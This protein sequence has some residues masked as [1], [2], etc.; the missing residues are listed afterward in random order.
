[1]SPRKS[2]ERIPGGVDSQTESIEKILRYVDSES[3][4][5]KELADWIEDEFSLEGDTRA[6]RVIRFL[7]GI[8]MLAKTGERLSPGLEGG[9]WLAEGADAETHFGTFDSEI[10]GFR[11]ILEELFRH[12]ANAKEL[13]EHLSES[14]GVGWETSEQVT[15]RLNYLRSIGYVEL[16]EGTY[17]L[18]EDGRDFIEGRSERAQ[19]Q[20]PPDQTDIVD[21]F[22]QDNPPEVYLVAQDIGNF[23]ESHILIPEDNRHDISLRKLSSNALFIHLVDD[24]FRGYSRQSEAATETTQNGTRYRRVPVNVVRFDDPVGIQGVIGELL[25]SDSI[26]RP[27]SYPFSAT[28]LTEVTIGE[29]GGD[30]AQTILSSVDADYTYAE[31]VPE[32]EFENPPTPDEIEDLYYPG[33]V[34]TEIIGQMVQALTGGQHIVL[35]GPPGTGKSELAKQV[36]AKLTDSSVTMVTATADWSSFDTIGGYQPEGQSGLNF[37]PGVFLDR[38]QDD[39]GNPTN[40]WL[41]VDELNRANVDKAFGSLFSALADDSVTTSFKDDDG[42]EI[43][44]VTKADVSGES[45]AAHRYCVPDTWRLIATMNTHDKMS[46]F[47]LSYAFIRRFAFI[48]VGAPSE[49]DIT[50]DAIEEYLTRWKIAIDADTDG[51]DTGAEDTAGETSP[52]ST[53]SETEPASHHDISSDDLAGTLSDEGVEQLK[54]YWSQLQPHRA[55][56][57]AVIEKVAR[58]FCGEGV[59]LTRPTKMYVIPQLED[60]PRQTQENAI[61]A[62]LDPE[63]DL[64]LK[65]EEII[66]FSED[67]LGIN[68]GDLHNTQA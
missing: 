52:D 11:E 34:L 36:A 19:F 7:V 50:T 24:E 28:G 67:Y 33:G 3:P 21:V 40:E 65:D 66:T 14:I 47:D 25:R 63:A 30:A 46:L 20:A 26:T 51:E 57:P 61:D 59:D 49:T 35:V 15:R 39:N 48:H 12:E 43:E 4:L 10:V 38:F 55:L 23:H 58:T 2:V 27:D 56:G 6:D 32:Y 31:A 62:L 54:Q 68:R 17:S 64:Q 13:N 41:I 42:N 18:S 29:L 9:K 5:V 22:D 44:L 16:E 45:V 1:M 37:S 53:E 8:N 60:L